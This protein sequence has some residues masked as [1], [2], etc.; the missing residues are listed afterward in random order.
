M[1]PALLP[2]R[3]KAITDNILTTEKPVTSTPR[4]KFMVESI[5]QQYKHCT[6]VIKS[7]NGPTRVLA[8]RVGDV[9]DLG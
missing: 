9:R 7:E 6:L 1:L 2:K 5:L 4:T 3:E 8:S